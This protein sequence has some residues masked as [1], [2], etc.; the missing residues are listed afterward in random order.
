M[1]YASGGELF[2]HIVK[3]RRLDEQEASFFFYQIINGLEHIHKNNIVHR[4]MKPENLLLSENKLLKIIDFG[5]SNQYKAG[6]LLQTPCGSPCYAAPEM[7]LGR[8]YSGLM[9]DIWSSGI[10]LYA[11]VCGYLPFEDKNNDKLYK[12]I[13]ECK[14][15]MPEHVSINCRD[16]IKKLLTVNPSKRIRLEEIKSHPFLKIGESV[17]G[18]DFFDTALNDKRLIDYVLNQMVDLGFDKSDVK[19]NLENN[20]H[21]NTTTTYDLLM[22]KAREKYDWIIAHYDNSK[23]QE[24]TNPSNNSAKLSFD[25]NKEDTERNITRIQDNAKESENKLVNFLPEVTSKT[26]AENISDIIKNIKLDNNLAKES[27]VSSENTPIENLQEKNSK[28]VPSPSSQTNNELD[29]KEKVTRGVNNKIDIIL[30]DFNESATSRQPELSV[31]STFRKENS[32]D[33]S[34]NP[35][36]ETKKSTSVSKNYKKEFRSRINPAVN[37]I[38]LDIRGIIEKNKNDSN[39][40]IL[41]TPVLTEINRINNKIKTKPQQQDVINVTVEESNFKKK[42]DTSMTVDTNYEM[43]SFREKNLNPKKINS[44]IPKNEI[45]LHDYTTTNKRDTSTCKDESQKPTR[46][47]KS[48]NSLNGISIDSPIT[49]RID[50]DVILT[51]YDKSFKILDFSQ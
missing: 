30:K 40:I 39:N 26:K 51:I 24:K 25:K 46:I 8:K 27:G 34:I 32:E 50:K 15:E 22:N 47:H 14:Y 41:G 2:N 3:K 1:E 11:M 43:N 29:S 7:I 18:K 9:V 31:L 45:N 28:Q 49:K 10:I 37:I 33:S 21:N 19:I 23:N 12:K 48:N 35:R 4:D 13:L 6:Q 20:K 44:L 36:Q 16:L 17:L 5:L 38:P 42:I